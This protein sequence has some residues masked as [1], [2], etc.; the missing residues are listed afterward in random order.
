MSNVIAQTQPRTDAWVKHGLVG[1]VIAGVVFA[2]FEMI[3]AAILNGTAAF[4]NPLRM[5]AG[6]ALGQQALQPGY[7]LA[8]VIVVGLILHMMLS[9]AFGVVFAGVL[10]SVPTLTGSPVRVLVTTSL[11]GIGLWLVNFYGI[12]TIAG[13]P[14]FP[15]RSNPIVQL[16]AHTIFFGAVLGLYLNATARRD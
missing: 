12:A 4:F 16:F 14:W 1:G 2:M 6:I 9:A 7:S 15:A 3:M 5:I 10:R 13:W 11:A 8:A